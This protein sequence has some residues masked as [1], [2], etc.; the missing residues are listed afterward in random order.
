MTGEGEIGRKPRVRFDCE[1]VDF[2]CAH[3]RRAFNFLSFLHTR[4][5]SVPCTDLC[6]ERLGRA[7]LS[8]E[9]GRSS[10]GE[11]RAVDRRPSGRAAGRAQAGSGPAVPVA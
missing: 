10:A 9:C 1:S 8:W 3:I 11:K 2:P 5:H 6:A 7:G 4:R